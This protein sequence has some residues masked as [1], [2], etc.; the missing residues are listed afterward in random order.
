MTM[1]TVRTTEEGMLRA[2]QLFDGTSQEFQA[3]L[4]S[5]RSSWAT[6]Q[7]SY[8]GQS[9]RMFG[10]G[11]NAWEEQF[12]TVLTGLMEMGHL[13][14]V[15][16]T[17]YRDAEESATQAAQG[18]GGSLPGSP[19]A[20]AQG[21]A[22]FPSMSAP[23]LTYLPSAPS[24]DLPSMSAPDLTGYPPVA[25]PDYPSISAPD[26]TGYPPVAAPDY[27][28]ISAPDLTSYPPVARPE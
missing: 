14:G 28:S 9:A 20:P 5:V 6:M 21:L 22:G 2:V 8:G 16:L 3:Y 10:D 11:V 12:M 13:M 27:P 1:P 19:S 26:L 17:S 18:F 4:I 7:E 25:G 23:D 15:T 24:P